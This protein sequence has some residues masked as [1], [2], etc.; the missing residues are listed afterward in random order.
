MRRSFLRKGTAAFAAMLMGANVMA[1]SYNLV[2]SIDNYSESMFVSGILF[3]DNESRIGL[4]V[5]DENG[6]I[7][8]ISLYDKNLNLDK[9]I[10]S[11]PLFEK[12]EG[13]TIYEEP[14]TLKVLETVVD[15]NSNFTPDENE[16]Y[17]LGDV[18]YP[19]YENFT[20]DVEP[21]PLYQYIMHYQNLIE[22]GYSDAKIRKYVEDFI[23]EWYVDTIYNG[24]R[25]LFEKWNVLEPE[26]WGTKYPTKGYFYRDHDEIYAV[27]FRY[28]VDEWQQTSKESR[29]IWQM[30]NMDNTYMYS[31]NNACSLPIETRFSQGLFNN[32]DNFEFIIPELRVFPSTSYDYDYHYIRDPWGNWG[33]IGSSIEMTIESQKII[34]EYLD[35]IGYKVVAEDGTVLHE[36]IVNEEVDWDIY[37]D[38]H[39]YM[40]NDKKYLA[41][42]SYREIPGEDYGS[43]Y[44]DHI[45]Q[46]Y[47]IKEDG[48]G[49]QKVR[50]MRGGMNIRPTV[51]NRDEQIT[52][53]LDDDNNSAAREL[54]ITSVNGQ[55]VERRTIPAGKS[56]VKVSA[57]MMRSGMYN[58]TLQKKGEVVDNG[59]VIVK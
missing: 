46:F 55:L 50:E 30:Y 21:D 51:A 23:K 18:I 9:E 27:M 12:F 32:D 7:S 11:G 47:E 57:A 34:N 38:C 33:G 2:R 35:P 44:I 41:I 53:T 6:F 52:I 26:K 15:T 13:F 29:G 49:I 56:S 58:F 3:N 36:V 45:A 10:S 4:V 25:L 31:D 22:D 24:E 40:W 59:K 16:P 5:D 28:G 19:F 48:T 14:K 39:I 1:Q 37:C 54:I 43:E 20:V 8:K 42:T 17:Y